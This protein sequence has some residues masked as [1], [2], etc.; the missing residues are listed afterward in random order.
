MRKLALG[1]LQWKPL[2]FYDA[3]LA[4]LGDAMD[5]FSE[6]EREAD[7]VQSWYVR[8][9]CFYLV[10]P[11]RDKNSTLKTEADMWPH[12]WDEEL[13]RKRLAEMPKAELIKNDEME[14]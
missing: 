1:K 9:I 13:K 2:E 12:P 14:N 5:G 11:H 8:K 6:H 10:A 3:T 4:E 7:N